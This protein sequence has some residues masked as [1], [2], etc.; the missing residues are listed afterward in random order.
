MVFWTESLVLCREGCSVMDTMQG[1][2]YEYTGCYLYCTRCN[3]CNTHT[4]SGRPS[5]NSFGKSK[6]NLLIRT[7]H[8]VLCH[9]LHEISA[10]H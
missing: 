5:G 10:M 6:K 9:L 1:V 7:T 4:P 3:T 2:M 8:K